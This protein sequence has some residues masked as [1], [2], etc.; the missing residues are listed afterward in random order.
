MKSDFEKNVKI[1]I[2]Y[3]KQECTKL[4]F[5]FKPE[6]DIF[7]NIVKQFNLKDNETNKIVFLN[8]CKEI[9]AD[10]NNFECFSLVNPFKD[11]NKYGKDRHGNDRPSLLELT[12]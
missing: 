5:K 6:A 10:K 1:V 8:D 4:G 9:F 3:F 7:F 11:Y 12:K 2:R